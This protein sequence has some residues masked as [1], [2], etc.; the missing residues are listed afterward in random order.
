MARAKCRAN[1]DVFLRKNT[2]G[3]IVGYQGAYF[4][5]NGKRR[6]VSSKSKE[7]ARRK[8]RAARAVDSSSMPRT[9][10]WGSISTAG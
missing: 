7:D 4:G 6:Y 9:S 3:R 5:P 10:R 2:E 8:L 1:G